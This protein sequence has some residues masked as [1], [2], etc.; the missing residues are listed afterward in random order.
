MTIDLNDIPLG[1]SESQQELK[2]LKSAK[3]Y[4][5]V[6]KLSES[7]KYTVM[8]VSMPVYNT[9]TNHDKFYRTEFSTIEE[10]TEVGF[11]CG[12][13]VFLDLSLQENLI[14]LKHDCQEKRDNIIDNIIE[15][16][17][18]K[19]DLNIKVLNC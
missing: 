11:F 6:F 12:Y 14:Q 3:I 13:K 17:K 15:G 2:I 4:R 5:E 10:I 19:K 18:I 9:L 16:V 8:V 1:I 7:N